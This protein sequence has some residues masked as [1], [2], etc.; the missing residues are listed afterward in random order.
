MKERLWIY[1]VP[2]AY[3]TREGMGFGCAEFKIGHPVDSLKDFERMADVIKAN[4][5]DLAAAMPINVIL[6]KVVG[7]DG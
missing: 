3:T 6:L 5:P 2:Y 7:G 4:N 1:A